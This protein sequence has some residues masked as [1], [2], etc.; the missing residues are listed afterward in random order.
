M[1]DNPAAD[2]KPAGVKLRNFEIVILVMLCVTLVLAIW[3]WSKAANAQNRVNE[4]VL[5]K[6]AEAA[7]AKQSRETQEVSACFATARNRP[8]IVRIMRTVNEGEK[9][10]YQRARVERLIVE[11]EHATIPGVDGV[12]TRSKCVV[13]ANRYEVD[14]TRY[15]FSERTG[16]LLH[17]PGAS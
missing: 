16:R 5:Q 7:A 12:P 1:S 4:L 3:G 10:P 13:L 6:K 17:P 2:S 15:D 9:D 11:Y 8:V 14:Y